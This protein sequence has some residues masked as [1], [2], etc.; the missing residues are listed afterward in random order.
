MSSQTS[1]DY[2]VPDT[3]VILA[4]SSFVYLLNVADDCFAVLVNAGLVGSLAVGVIF[5]PEVANILPGDVQNTFVILGYVGLILLVFE[6][7][8]STNIALLFSNFV[9]SLTIALSGVAFPV[10][11]SL[12]VLSYGFGFTMLQSF[13]CGAALCSTS[14]GTTLGLL[15]PE[16]RQTKTGVILLS[17]A[18]LDDVTGLIFAAIVPALPSNG[19]KSSQLKWYTIARPV[20]V[21]LAFGFGTAFAAFLMRKGLL[22]FPVT[23][24]N[25]LYTTKVMLFIMVA[26]LSGFVAGAQYA[27][28][29]ELFGAYLAG[30]LLQHVFP[31]NQ[32]A[33]DEN[34]KPSP[35][36]IDKFQKPA[37]TFAVYIYPVLHRFFSPVFFGSIGA[38]LPVRSLFL[39]D[40]S[41]RVIW[42]GIIYATLMIFAK[43]VVGVWILIWPDRDL[44]YGWCGLKRKDR[45]PA[46]LHSPS[47]DTKPD[48]KADEPVMISMSRESSATLIALAMVARGEIGLIVAQLARPLLVGDTATVANKSSEPFA[49]VVQY[50]CTYAII[51]RS[52]GPPLESLNA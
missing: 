41:R 13:G 49:V 39:V 45:R 8:L 48:G 42:H 26:V 30:A 28:T 35:N 16:L 22:L 5:G 4:T 19:S 34:M 40:G 9:L 32:G 33:R 21:S 38:A 51:C 3:P 47:G 44:G 12:V 23:L 2:T 20:L 31:P 24:K 29:S 14:L 43:A 36:P 11:I 1:F 27:G 52:P 15:R 10:I 7:G 37:S 18:L 50:G 6:A 17:A 25:V 46:S